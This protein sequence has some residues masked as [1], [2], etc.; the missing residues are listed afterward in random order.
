[1]HSRHHHDLVRAALHTTQRTEIIC[2][3]FAERAI[4][5]PVVPVLQ[6]KKSESS[7]PAYEVVNWDSDMNKGKS[8]EE[9]ARLLQ[10]KFGLKENA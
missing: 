4:A 7:E 8:F 10:E 6:P 5:A 1:M 2:D 9:R 3:G